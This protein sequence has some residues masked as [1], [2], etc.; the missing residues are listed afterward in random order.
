MLTESSLDS[1]PLFPISEASFQIC[2]CWVFSIFC[3]KWVSIKTNQQTY[4]HVDIFSSAYIILIHST[5]LGTPGAIR[6]EKQKLRC[7]NTHAR[8]N[9]QSIPK[10]LTKF[11]QKDRHTLAFILKSLSNFSKTQAR[12]TCLCLRLWIHAMCQFT[13]PSYLVRIRTHFI[14]VV[15]D[16]ALVDGFKRLV[17]NWR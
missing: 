2:T 3:A 4:R 5:H 8:K 14:P 15:S 17:R 6:L 11:E 16:M 7:T 9:N 13:G 1:R 12:L 10:F